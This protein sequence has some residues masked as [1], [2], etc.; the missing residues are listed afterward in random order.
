MTR[1]EIRDFVFD[2]VKK[3]IV[4]DDVWWSKNSANGEN[5][6]W[7]SE[8][9]ADSLDTIELILEI[10]RELNII[11][12]EDVFTYEDTL[13]TIIDKIYKEANKNANSK[14]C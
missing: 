9:G 5:L 4:Y 1:E 14:T 11:V 6:L 7:Y 8:I 13:G 2:I 12:P 3:K 10:E